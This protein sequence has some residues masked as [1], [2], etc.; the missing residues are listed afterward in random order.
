M[1]EVVDVIERYEFII[2]DGVEKC[3]VN[4]WVIDSNIYLKLLVESKLYFED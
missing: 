2:G 4:V 3:K 1:V